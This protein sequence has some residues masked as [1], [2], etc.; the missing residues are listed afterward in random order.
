MFADLHI[1]KMDESNTPIKKKIKKLDG[2]FLRLLDR[3][4]KFDPERIMVSDLGDSLNTDGRFRT[5]SGKVSLQNSV[6]EE[7]AFKYLMDWFI[8][9]IDH[10]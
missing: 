7:D 8:K 5:T 9:V 2:M 6:G 4:M 10:V 1:D 3:V